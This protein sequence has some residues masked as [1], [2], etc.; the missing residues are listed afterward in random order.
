MATVFSSSLFSFNKRVNLMAADM[1][2]LSH[3]AG[4]ALVF[5]PIREG[6]CAVTAFTRSYNRENKAP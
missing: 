4:N 6:Q 3:A 2:K 1:A 5:S